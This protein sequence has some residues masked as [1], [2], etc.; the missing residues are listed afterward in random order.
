M[1][2]I[3]EEKS[4]GKALDKILKEKK[5]TDKRGEWTEEKNMLEDKSERKDSE[6]TGSK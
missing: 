2:R 6:G 4:K 1:N 3:E 5:R